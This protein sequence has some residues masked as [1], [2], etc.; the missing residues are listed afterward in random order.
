VKIIRLMSAVLVA[1][2]GLLAGIASSARADT[3]LLGTYDL[4]N[5]LSD[6]G[7][8]VVS[9]I[10]GGINVN[11]Q[12][13]SGVTLGSPSN[14]GPDLFFT[15]VGTGNPFQTI[16]A[17]SGWQAVTGN[18]NL[19]G[20]GVETVGLNCTTGCNS[21]SLQFN[22]TPGNFSGFASVAN[23]YFVADV[24]SGGHSGLVGASLVSGVPEPSTWAM[25]VLGFLGLGVVFRQ[26]RRKV[27]FA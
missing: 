2:F 6:Y 4:S 5:G 12:L 25:I 14:L 26:S 9:S 23:V 7:K 1:G 10:A 3:H 27:S 21:S 24:S 19:L 13:A 22:I 20:F 18:F 17:P 11:V 16:N 15:L 8:I